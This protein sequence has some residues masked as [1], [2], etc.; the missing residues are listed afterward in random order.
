MLG[1][2]SI[3]FIHRRVAVAGEI[4][5]LTATEYDLLAELA[6]NAGR[7]VTHGEVPQRVWGPTNPSSPRTIRTHLMRLGQNLGEDGENP[8]YVFAE[9]RVG[10]W[11]AVGETV[12]AE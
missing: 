10:Y 9:P 4:V 8:V 3:D 1:E 2:L 5:Q 6:V 11:M 12:E 7:V